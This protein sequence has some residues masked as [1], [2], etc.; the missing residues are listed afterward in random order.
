MQKYMIFDLDGTLINSMPLWKNVGKDYLNRYGFLPPSD[1]D[2][3]VKKQTLFETASYV[4]QLFDIPK[5]INEM[6]AEIIAMVAEQYANTVP[7]KPFAK[8]YLQRSVSIKVV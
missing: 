1:L 6:V 4:K 2:D 8:Q 3:K 5:T 7:L